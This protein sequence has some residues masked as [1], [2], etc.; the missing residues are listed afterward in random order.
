MTAREY[1]DSFNAA[2]QQ[3]NYPPPPYQ[4]FPAGQESQQNA[5]QPAQQ[6]QPFP[7]Y[8][9]GYPGY[10]HPSE[11]GHQGSPQSQPPPQPHYH[12]PQQQYQQ[13]YSPQPQHHQSYVQNPQTDTHHSRP[14]Y[15]TDRLP[16]L[17]PERSYSEPPTT[18]HLHPHEAHSHHHHQRHS[19]SPSH[20][21][22]R[23]RSSS[24]SHSRHRSRR[25]SHSRSRPR[26]SHTNTK[27]KGRNT[28]FGAFGGGLLGDAIFPGLGTVG[29]AVLGGVLGKESAKNTRPRSHRR[30]KG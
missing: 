2:T 29:G 3:P 23:S 7:D 18:S 19:R 21:R 27:H 1:Y 9:A 16:H 14:P 24:R 20:S 8:K 6:Q 30:S 17:R 28:F 10:P 11:I 13:P 25:R 4:P 15:S 12:T 5:V 22:S 26:S